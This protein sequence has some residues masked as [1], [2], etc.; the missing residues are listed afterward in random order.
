M[1]ITSVTSYIIPLGFS[2]LL[3][4]VVSLL[5][6]PE[7]ASTSMATNL[8]TVL[9]TTRKI[10]HQSMGIF[11]DPPDDEEALGAIAKVTA[12]SSGLRGQRAK[13]L[14]S[15]HDSIFEL[16]Y[17]RL[18][19]SGVRAIKSLLKRMNGPT[20]AIAAACANEKTLLEQK[21]RNSRSSSRRT[22][23]AHVE[24]EDNESTHETENPLHRMWS[25]IK[26]K[27]HLGES[28]HTSLDDDNPHPARSILDFPMDG[29]VNIA[30][31]RAV[32]E[33]AFGDE[34]LVQRL[35]SEL[36]GPMDA[37]ARSINLGFLQCEWVFATSFDLTDFT[38]QIQQERAKLLEHETTE[39]P[40]QAQSGLEPVTMEMLSD[41]RARLEVQIENYERSC[42][43]RLQAIG[44]RTDFVREEGFL[45]AMLLVNLAEVARQTQEMVSIAQD[46]LSKRHARRSLW[47]PRI[48][49]KKFF[50][51]GAESGGSSAF[52]QQ[53]G[54]RV[55][56]DEAT[57]VQT[58]DSKLPK[59][60]TAVKEKPKS[61]TQWWSCLSRS[62]LSARMT[63][64]QRSHHIQYGLKVAFAMSFLIFPVF[65]RDWRVWFS[66][67]RGQWTLI[68]ALVVLETSLGLSIQTGILRV[69]GTVAGSVW[70]YLAYQ[71]GGSLGNAYV[72]AV[73]GAIFALPMF[74]VI[75][76]S[77]YPK[78]GTVA[79]ISFNTVAMSFYINPVLNQSVARVAF[80]RG[81]AAVVGVVFAVALNNI[82]FPYKA[83][84][85]LIKLTSKTFRDVGTLY[86]TIAETFYRAD[87]SVNVKQNEKLLRKMEAKL[88]EELTKAS[89]LLKITAIEPRL[90][91]PFPI[92]IFS[93]LV[94]VLQSISDRLSGLK[95]INTYIGPGVRHDIGDTLSEHRKD[96]IG[97]IL[98]T[99]YAISYALRSR[100]PMPQF[101]PSARLAKMRIING[102][103]KIITDKQGLQDEEEGLLMAPRAI[104]VPFR[105]DPH[106]I[107]WFANQEALE[108]IIELLE[109]C[110]FLVKALVGET[111]FLDMDFGREEVT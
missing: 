48:K 63:S 78:A 50:A 51:S 7:S 26:G 27:V 95:V 90:K 93:E 64:I 20:Q 67:I 32:K 14:A 75:L 81:A 58:V 43:D 21:T 55:A 72:I 62:S 80:L 16:S 5:I 37:L 22:N 40:D 69:A 4:L 88:D 94:T 8:L 18:P 53:R 1:T 3:S 6:W 12:A 73:F 11:I 92:D 33:I 84:Q 107:Y 82:L 102:V 45:V 77:A 19:P 35:V 97:A 34:N 105:L 23:S 13:F 57:P 29:S 25:T 39:K 54:P 59:P 24:D 108:E 60:T 65:I 49:W 96:F 68:N 41:Y 79:L 111:E 103:R 15:Y 61:D 47:L 2:G 10:V 106:Y 38:K 83:R 44:E 74:Y 76:N 17:S 101:L 71:P 100:E 42:N 109:E 70:G 46:L 99:L 86:W 87:P 66:G 89:T 104:K 31:L 30:S 110:V 52:V 91:G 28:S 56:D 98:L 36:E 85:Q 9:A